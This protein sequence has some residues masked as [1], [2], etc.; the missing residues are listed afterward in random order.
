[1]VTE[2]GA[3]IES[4]SSLTEFRQFLHE[5]LAIPKADLA[6]VIEKRQQSND[7]LAMLLWQYGFISLEQL[8]RIFDWF[9]SQAALGVKHLLERAEG[10]K[11]KICP[12][13]AAFR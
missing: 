3:V 7:P 6:M 11:A 13:V 12:L 9:D 4:N 8:Q 5:E 2:N 10:K 1:M